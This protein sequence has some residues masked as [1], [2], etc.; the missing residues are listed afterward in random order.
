MTP[1][2]FKAWFDGFTEAF[3]GCPTTAQWARIKERV[4]EIDGKE[5]TE[6][7]YV[8]RYWMTYYRSYPYYTP[9]Y[10][11]VSSA[12]GLGTSTTT[13]GLQSSGHSYNSI[14]AMNM[15]GK[16]DAQSLSQ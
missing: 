4:T 1:R 7:V 15:L 8:D 12:G 5:V 11:G 16:A 14:A 2:E 9:P 3:T 6:H 13:Q 10:Y